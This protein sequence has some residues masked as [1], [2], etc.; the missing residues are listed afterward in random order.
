MKIIPVFSHQNGLI[1]GVDCTLGEG[2]DFCVVSMT[3]VRKVFFIRINIYKA[4]KYRNDTT[5]SMEL[6]SSPVAITHKQLKENM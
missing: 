6:H 1:V 5:E 4:Y 3:L 2:N